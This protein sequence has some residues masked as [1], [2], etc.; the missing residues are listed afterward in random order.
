MR[1]PVVNVS[2]LQKQLNDLQLE[3]QLLRNILDRSGISYASE[4]RR[5]KEPEAAESFDPDQGARIIH[6][7]VFTNRMV[8]TYL[9]CFWEDMMY[10]PEDR[11]RKTG[12]PVTSASAA[13]SGR[14]YAQESTGRRSAAETVLTDPIKYWKQKIYWP[15][16]R[17]DP[18]MLPT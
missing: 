11:K 6:P 12:R 17:E 9:S 10:M 5:L 3:N 7:P 4:L 2:S 15:I 8:R 1:D 14:R 16:S 13:T 18:P